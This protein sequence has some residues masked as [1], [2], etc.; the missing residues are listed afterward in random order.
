MKTCPTNNNEIKKSLKFPNKGFVILSAVLII[1]IIS[2]SVTVSLLFSG[3]NAAL[4]GLTISQSSRASI[5][6]DTCAQEAMERIRRDST[7]IGNETISM[8]EDS[9]EILPVQDLGAESRLVQIQGNSGEVNRKVEIRIS[10]IEPEIRVDY[11][12]EVAD[13]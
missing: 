9:C 3:I 2:L 10:Q 11:W 6:A 7:Y 12:Y 1:G 5:M 4:S 13:F 8:G